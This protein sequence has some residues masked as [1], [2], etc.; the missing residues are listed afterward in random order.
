MIPEFDSAMAAFNHGDANPMRQHMD[1]PLKGD[2]EDCGKE[3]FLHPH[4]KNLICFPCM[5]SRDSFLK[6]VHG[7]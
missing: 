4:G 5:F 7:A 1:L 6:E 3:E 2:C